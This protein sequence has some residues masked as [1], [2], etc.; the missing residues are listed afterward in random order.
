MSLIFDHVSYTYS[1]DTAY[2]VAALNDIN[3]KIDDGEFLLVCFH[4]GEK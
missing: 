3:L 2:E 1:P 4:I